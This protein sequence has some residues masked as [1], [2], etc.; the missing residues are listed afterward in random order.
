MDINNTSNHS[1]NSNIINNNNRISKFLPTYK[2][3]NNLDCK[4]TVSLNSKI[5]NSKK[6][7][8]L[9]NTNNNNRNLNNKNQGIKKYLN[10]KL[11]LMLSTLAMKTHPRSLTS[12]MTLKISTNPRLSP[13]LTLILHGVQTKRLSKIKVEVILILLLGM[14]LMMTKKKVIKNLELKKK[15][16][17]MLRKQ[18]HHNLAKLKIKFQ[19]QLEILKEMEMTVV[20]SKAMMMTRMSLL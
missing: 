6:D 2:T 20:V 9:L 15:R 19:V 18:N 16:K 11:Q 13:P 8:H 4:L 14:M 12:V 1:S 7:N 3:H 5:T 10:K 17:K